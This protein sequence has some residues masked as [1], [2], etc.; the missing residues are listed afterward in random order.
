MCFGKEL[1]EWWKEPSLYDNCCG[2]RPRIVEEE[3]HHPLQ[4]HGFISIYC[5]S[6]GA[7]IEFYV[8]TEAYLAWNHMIRTG[9]GRYPGDSHR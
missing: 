8:P 2:C 9:S 3:A 4:V 5:D 6:C 1:A 7:A